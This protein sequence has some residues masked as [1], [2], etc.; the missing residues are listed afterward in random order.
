MKPY[1]YWPL[2][3]GSCAITQHLSSILLFIVAF[4]YLYN[5]SLDPRFLV[6]ISAGMFLVGLVLWELLD[7]IDSGWATHHEHGDYR[8]LSGS[9]VCINE[10]TGT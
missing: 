9:S 2:V 8:R 7:R 3:V 4:V 6:F 5:G 1:T 10:L